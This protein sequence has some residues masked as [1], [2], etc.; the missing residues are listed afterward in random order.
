MKVV[1]VVGTQ[2][3]PD[4]GGDERLVAVQVEGACK[5]LEDLAGDAFGIF[6]RSDIGQDDGEFR[7]SFHDSGRGFGNADLGSLSG[8]FSRGSN[9]SDIVGSGLGLTI[10]DEVARSHDGR[11]ELTTNDG[12][13]GACVSLVFSHS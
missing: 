6:A 12:G 11:L 13:P 4:A 7:M 2:R 3:N 1:T 9:V 8:R 10:A 5:G